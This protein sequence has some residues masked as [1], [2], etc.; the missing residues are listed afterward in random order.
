IQCIQS[1]V[2]NKRTGWS[3]GYMKD[4]RDDRL[5]YVALWQRLQLAAMP[6]HFL[7]DAQAV[8]LQLQVDAIEARRSVE[9]VLL[10]RYLADVELKQHHAASTTTAAA[11]AVSSSYS[12]WNLV[13][14]TGLDYS[15]VKEAQESGQ[16]LERQELYR[17]LGYDPTE[18][19]IPSTSSTEFSVISIQLNQG[20]IALLND[21]DTKYLRTSS[22]Y[23]RRYNPQTFFMALF[24]QRSGENMNMEV[25][26]Q[27][28]ELYDESMDGYC[29]LKRRVP[30]SNLN[31]EITM[32]APVFRLS[33]ENGQ[34]QQTLKLFMEPLE[35]IYSP[36]A[37]CWAHLSTFSTA[38]EALGLW[39]EM[40]MQAL[41][42][43]V[44]VKARTE[45]KV[46]YAMA[47]RIPIVVDVRIQVR[48]RL[49]LDLG[50]V[51][52]RTERLSNLN[53]DITSI[54]TTAVGSGHHQRA[55]ASVMMTNSTN[56]SKQLT[57]EAESGEGLYNY[58]RRLCSFAFK[59]GW[60]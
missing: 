14:W 9:D 29:I 51:H 54:S 36:T 16:E 7:G 34:H 39:A 11:A 18:K 47:H 23:S 32:V 6:E 4:R 48:A 21:P 60:W 38:P 13:K 30:V 37:I 41:N 57:D 46:E 1:D 5:Q 56:F 2:A 20:S 28:V 27:T 8:T 19:S 12:L 22:Q 50:H 59:L 33:Y 3:W 53:V 17:I 24:A 43:F 25:S 52:F 35:V 10:F 31:V 45:A 42:E 26:L 49:I 44:N 58:F 15:T 40:E 55:A